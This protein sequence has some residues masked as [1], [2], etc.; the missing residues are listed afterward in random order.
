MSEQTKPSEPKGS[1]ATKASIWQR[2][3]TALFGTGGIAV[4]VAALISVYVAAA[5]AGH[6]FPFEP[7]P[8]P[9]SSPTAPITTTPA[10]TPGTTSTPVTA[11]LLDTALLPQSDLGNATVPANP[12]GFC[13]SYPAPSTI[14][15]ISNYEWDSGGPLAGFEV[16]W[17]G[18]YSDVATAT[19]VMSSIPGLLPQC[20]PAIFSYSLSPLSGQSFC[21]QTY[22]GA[23]DN[24]DIG[25]SFYDLYLGLIRCGSTIEFLKLQLDPGSSNLADFQS[26]LST[27]AGQLTSALPNS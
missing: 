19:A 7:H 25:G 13:S 17:V 9:T 21:D 5:A 14:S 23:A 26:L 3:S 24:V 15:S 27:A 22:Q 20:N 2:L 1:R 16:N 6:W 10:T 18:S 8:S 12:V 4:G 11:S